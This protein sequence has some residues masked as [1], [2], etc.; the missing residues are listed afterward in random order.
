MRSIIQI[1]HTL[2]FSARLSPLF[3]ID[4]TV[5]VRYNDMF[6][7]SPV[8]FSA[9]WSE[10][11]REQSGPCTFCIANPSCY[12]VKLWSKRLCFFQLQCAT[13]EY[14]HI[15]KWLLA[16]K[17]V[18][19]QGLKTVHVALVNTY[20]FLYRYLSYFQPS[21]VRSG[22]YH[23]VRYSKQGKVQLLEQIP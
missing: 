21:D 5:C 19:I 13:V 10:W 15:M 23:G 17:L 8:P 16:L 14:I 7:S 4:M 11:Q 1:S 9:P 20:A 18:D 22:A 2:T 6:S 3:L 12:I